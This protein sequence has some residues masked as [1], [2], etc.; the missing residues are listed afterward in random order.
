MVM[1]L[2]VKKA[3][4]HFVVRGLVSTPQASPQF[5]QRGHPKNRRE[6]KQ[7]SI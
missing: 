3:V 4:Y 5:Y 2:S 1:T 6:K 7:P